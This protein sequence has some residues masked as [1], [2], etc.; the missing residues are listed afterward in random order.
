M[1]SICV[2]G[3]FTVGA[4]QEEGQTQAAP[5]FGLLAAEDGIYPHVGRAEKTDATDAVAA[6]ERG[7]RQGLRGAAG[8]RSPGG[9]RT[10]ASAAGRDAREASKVRLTAKGDW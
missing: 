7:E 4:L 2:D 1:A 9:V 5:S 8:R 3:T 10:G 6:A